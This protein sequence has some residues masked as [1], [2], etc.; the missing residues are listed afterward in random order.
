M[1]HS[2]VFLKG[3]DWA[4]KQKCFLYL[5]WLLQRHHNRRAEPCTVS[6]GSLSP[7]VS[8]GPRLSGKPAWC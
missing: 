3:P 2:F 5:K 1:G 8:Q 7:W 6:Q 4:S